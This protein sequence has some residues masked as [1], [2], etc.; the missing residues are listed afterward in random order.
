MLLDSCRY[1]GF[2]EYAK[3]KGVNIGSPVGL[4][5]VVDGI[6]PTGLS[7]SHYICITLSF[8]PEVF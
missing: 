1:K 7:A 3:S 6:V 2:H 8:H 4:D 5:V